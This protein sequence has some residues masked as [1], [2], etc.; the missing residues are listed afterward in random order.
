MLPR[1]DV[2]DL[3]LHRLP[4]PNDVPGEISIAEDKYEVPYEINNLL[5]Q[6]L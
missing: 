4:N 2:V 5:D 3:L 1:Y 6:L